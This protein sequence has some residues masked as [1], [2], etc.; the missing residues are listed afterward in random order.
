MVT[1]SFMQTSCLGVA[2][3]RQLNSNFA[4]PSVGF[5]ASAVKQAGLHRW[6]RSLHL[7]KE[8]MTSVKSSLLEFEQVNLK[9]GAAGRASRE[10]QSRLKS[11]SGD[12][13]A[14]RWSA[15]AAGPPATVLLGSADKHLGQYSSILLDT[16]DAPVP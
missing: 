5:E 13:S 16:T 9:N 7:P 12:L 14:A 3:V 1:G 10:Y 6:A 4:A 8:G 2:V 11:W 15:S